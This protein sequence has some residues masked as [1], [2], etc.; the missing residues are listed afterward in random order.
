[1]PQTNVDIVNIIHP[2]DMTVV[3]S[4]DPADHLLVTGERK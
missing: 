2:A 1:M 4:V 3:T